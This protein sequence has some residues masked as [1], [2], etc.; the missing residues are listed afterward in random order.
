MY[1]EKAVNPPRGDGF[2]A[3]QDLVHLVLADIAGV[4]ARPKLRLD[5]GVEDVRLDDAV[6][7]VLR[8][9]VCGVTLFPAGR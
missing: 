3:H 2:H 5:Q 8:H 1:L 7:D 9:L 4:H 6:D